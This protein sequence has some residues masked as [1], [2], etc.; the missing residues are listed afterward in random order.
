M[1]FNVIIFLMKLYKKKYK[2]INTCIH[3]NKYNDIIK[4][5]LINT[6]YYNTD[7]GTHLL[8]CLL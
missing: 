3:L 6:G 1:H 7:T 4:K 5:Y 8:K 2:P